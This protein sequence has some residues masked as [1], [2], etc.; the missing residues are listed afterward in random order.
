MFIYIKSHNGNFGIQNLNENNT[1]RDL[2]EEIKKKLKMNIPIKKMRLRNSRGKTLK[3][4]LSLIDSEVYD[5]TT[6]ILDANIGAFG[7]MNQPQ[8]DGKD[9]DIN[10]FVYDTIDTGDIVFVSW[11][12]AIAN[13]YIMNEYKSK[14]YPKHHNVFRQQL[15]I[16]LL[17][18]AVNINKNINMYSIDRGFKN[19]TEYDIRTILNKL[20]KPINISEI[21]LYSINTCELLHELGIDCVYTDSVINYYFIPNIYGYCSSTTNPDINKCLIELK[22]NLDNL[23]VEYYIYEKPLD[24]STMITNNNN[25]GNNIKDWFQMDNKNKKG[26]GINPGRVITGENLNENVGR[27]IRLID[28]QGYSDRS[29]Y[30]IRDLTKTKYIQEFSGY[31]EGFKFGI[32]LEQDE[33]DNE[34]VLRRILP[35]LESFETYA[36]VKYKSG[37]YYFLIPK[38][39]QD[40]RDHG[41]FP[42]YLELANVG[43]PPYDFNPELPNTSIFSQLEPD[44]NHIF[45][46]YQIRKKLTQKKKLRDAKQKLALSRVPFDN[47]SIK[48][49]NEYLSN[50]DRNPELHNRMVREDNSKINGGKKTKKKM[51]RKKT[52]KKIRGGTGTP[53]EN[54]LGDDLQNIFNHEEDYLY[55]ENPSVLT[56][57][58]ELESVDIYDMPVEVMGNIASNLNFDNCEELRNYCLI[59]PRDCALDEKFKE[60]YGIDIKLCKIEANIKKSSKRF[61]QLEPS[62]ELIEKINEPRGSYELIGDQGLRTVE[63]K[64]PYPRFAGKILTDIFREQGIFSQIQ[65]QKKIRALINVTFMDI[66]LFFHKQDPRLLDSILDQWANEV[67]NKKEKLEKALENNY[68]NHPEPVEENWSWNPRDSDWIYSR[69]LYDTDEEDI[70]LLQKTFLDSMSDYLEG[71]DLYGIIDDY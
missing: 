57:E 37:F 38:T 69:W 61:F 71:E 22:N 25:I 26:G 18:Y 19:I 12:N 4:E 27:L 28:T 45:S 41:V 42:Y 68:M 63:S 65:R 8:I 21:Q 23:G 55:P 46:A 13:P 62:L 51:K 43:L 60:K 67:I 3:D 33:P 11:G 7:E 47:T 52:M 32:L 5:N 20:T 30:Q 17:E 66:V 44:R 40:I 31:E 58:D 50:I 53:D 16:P 24:I 34:Y 70:L 15:P 48:K 14:K 1:V 9:F 59:N 54:L 2:K 64:L 29:P 35:E 56:N 39:F 49:I 10:E 36:K 6:L